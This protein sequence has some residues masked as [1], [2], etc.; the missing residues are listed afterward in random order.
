MM[1]VKLFMHIP[2]EDNAKNPPLEHP[3]SV[4]GN[5]A[6]QFWM[7]R[8]V[9][10]ISLIA[11]WKLIFEKFSVYVIMP[12]RSDHVMA[13]KL[14]EYSSPSVKQ[15]PCNNRMIPRVSWPLVGA[16]LTVP[17]RRRFIFSKTRRMC[18]GDCVLW[19]CICVRV[20]VRIELF[21]IYIISYR[22]WLADSEATALV[23]SRNW[24]YLH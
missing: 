19:W 8:R 11:N 10:W 2:A 14:L 18:V 17:G 20:C 13:C 3:M 5:S 6:W 15:P 7:T 21:R 24:R 9:C 4:N 1:F 23:S 16:R 22:S 12:N